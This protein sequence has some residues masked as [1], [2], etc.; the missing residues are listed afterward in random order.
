M[1]LPRNQR[2]PDV[3]RIDGI[4]EVKTTGQRKNAANVDRS[5]VP[6]NAETGHLAWN[7]GTVLQKFGRISLIL[8]RSFE[9]CL[10]NVLYV[11]GHGLK[12]NQKS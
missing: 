1:L 7:T 8:N 5:H 12:T 4:H 3:A 6:P 11:C 10:Y 9:G 2:C